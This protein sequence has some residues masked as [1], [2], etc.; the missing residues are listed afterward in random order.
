MSEN[1]IVINGKKAELTEEQLEKLGIRLEKNKYVEMFDRRTNNEPYFYIG[2]SGIV[3]ITTE[4]KSQYDDG[5][6]KCAN[7]CASGEILHQRALRETLNRLLWRASVIA[8]ELDNP[9]EAPTKH[10]Y[11]YKSSEDDAYR[12]WYNDSDNAGLAYFPTE[13]SA[14]D[15]IKNIVEPFM[16]EHPDFRW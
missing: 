3:A 7:Y 10:Y 1:Y 9:W 8:G 6:F 11:I 13:R 16:K 4:L 2:Q 15:A 12:V 5:L 14:K